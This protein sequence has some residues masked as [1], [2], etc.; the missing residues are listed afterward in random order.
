MTILQTSALSVTARQVWR[1]VARLCVVVAGVFCVFVAATLGF[2]HPAT[3]QR[4]H[5]SADLPPDFEAML[6]QL[7]GVA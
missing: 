2:T 1:R 5:F 6:A 4:L 7:R 3:G